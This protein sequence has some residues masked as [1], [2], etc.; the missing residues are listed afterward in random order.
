MTTLKKLKQELLKDAEVRAEYEA[1][2]LEHEFARSLIAA[3]LKA[4]LTQQE[5]ARR[6]GTKQEAVA[7]IESGRHLPS[8]RTTQRYAQAIGCALKIDLRPV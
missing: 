3:R 1:L 7:R 4:G 5:V 2:A 8:I 6:M